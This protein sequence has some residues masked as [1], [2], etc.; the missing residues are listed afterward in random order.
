M[1]PSAGSLGSGFR[2]IRSALSRSRRAC[3]TAGPAHR[4][5]FGQALFAMRSSQ[6]L[7]CFGS[8]GACGDTGPREASNSLWRGN[9][10]MPRSF[11]KR[12]ISWPRS[13]KSLTIG[14]QAARAARS[15]LWP[16]SPH[17]PA[18]ALFSAASSS[19]SY[20]VS[21]SARRLSWRSRR[22]DLLTAGYRR[23]R[24][25]TSRTS[26]RPG[27]LPECPACPAPRP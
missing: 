4:Q 23:N 2:K 1:R 5:R 27:R 25:C 19:A 22:S 24:A 8:P 26:A 14:S 6:A 10:S 7:A 3:R 18:A 11:R 17:E 20:S 9:G 12:S 21:S 15:A 16:N 13:H